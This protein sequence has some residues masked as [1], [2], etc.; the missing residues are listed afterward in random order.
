MYRPNEVI[1][2]NMKTTCSINLPIAGHCRPTRNCA[3]TCYAKTGP[4]SWENSLKKYRWVSEYL[5]GDDISQLIK[6]CRRKHAVRIS[7]AG[8]LLME[9][10]PNMLKLAEALPEI[11]F[12][13]MTRKLEIAR[14]LNKKVPNLRILVSLDSSSPLETESYE[15]KMCFGPRLE[16]D[17]VPNDDRIIVVFPFHNRG[18]IAKTMPLHA[19]DCPAV[20]HKV[21]NCLECTR[22]WTW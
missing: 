4:I 21:A 13:G 16:T 11:P 15:G 22:C 19:K 6:E 8:D 20:Y 1:S 7:G 9:H 14:A 10:V 17:D 3:A 12:Y 18:K 5:K 2:D